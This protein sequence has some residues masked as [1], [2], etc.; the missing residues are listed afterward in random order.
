MGWLWCRR[1]FENDLPSSLLICPDVTTLG[2]FYW[3][4]YCAAV[5]NGSTS[6]DE[7]Q[8]MRVWSSNCTIN[9][10]S[11]NKFRAAN[12]RHRH[13]GRPLPWL[14]RPSLLLV[15]EI[16]KKLRITACLRHESCRA[17]PDDADV[18]W[19]NKISS[20]QVSKRFA[21]ASSNDA[22]RIFITACSLLEDSNPDWVKPHPSI[23]YLYFRQMSITFVFVFDIYSDVFIWSYWLWKSL[24]IY[25][26]ETNTGRI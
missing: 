15:I 22:N 19:E 6:L 4:F 13:Q 18:S 5:K 9:V 26:H 20:H 25:I 23:C 11:L 3:I 14:T 24:L 1:S 12:G 8:L 2:I 7:E 16:T 10:F 17:S 21:V